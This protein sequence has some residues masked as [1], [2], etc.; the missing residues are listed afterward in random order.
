MSP[1]RELP[2]WPRLLAM[3]T[4][5]SVLY[6]AIDFSLPILGGGTIYLFFDSLP[7]TLFIHFLIPF[8]ILIIFFKI[9]ERDTYGVTKKPNATK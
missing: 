7:I 2:E 8:S 9:L 4:I 6:T 5:V 3:T 1:R